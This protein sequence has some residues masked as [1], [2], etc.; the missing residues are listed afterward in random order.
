MPV[1]WSVKY[2]TGEETID[3]QHQRLFDYVNR[4]E[5][6][7]NQDTVEGEIV[8]AVLQYMT[9][10]AQTHFVYEELCMHRVKCPTAKVNQEAHDKFMA[11]VS[12]YQQ[13]Y[14]KDGATRELVNE[15]YGTASN[16]LTNHI[17]KIDTQLRG[18][19]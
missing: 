6:Q 19:K 8:G 2:A 15:M 7:L 12:R 5:T 17:C 3:A 13:Q 1:Y 11:L 9:M 16:W 10:Y 18:C 4:L 14:D